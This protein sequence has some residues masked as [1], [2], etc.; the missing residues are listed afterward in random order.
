MQGV[1]LGGPGVGLEQTL[2]GHL[3]FLHDRLSVIAPAVERGSRAPTPGTTVRVRG[4]P[5]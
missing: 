2:S 4:R 5:T 3:R 1:D